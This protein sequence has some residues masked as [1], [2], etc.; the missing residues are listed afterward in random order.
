MEPCD[1]PESSADCIQHKTKFFCSLVTLN[2]KN[3]VHLAMAT[4]DDNYWSLSV[5]WSYAY[6]R[7]C[8]QWSQR[9]VL[10]TKQTLKP[11]KILMRNARTHPRHTSYFPVV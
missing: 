11:H 3:T 10:A 8:L 7:N 5:L 4:F 6:P 2:V 1:F 9:A